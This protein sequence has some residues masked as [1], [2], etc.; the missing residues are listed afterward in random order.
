MVLSGEWSSWAIWE[1][2]MRSQ[3][4]SGAEPVL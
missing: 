2:T 1:A 4:R 3:V